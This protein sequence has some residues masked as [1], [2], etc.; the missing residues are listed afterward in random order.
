MQYIDYAVT[1]LSIVG[2]IANSFQKRWCFWVWGFTNTFW[3]VFNI[4]NGSYAQAILYAFNFA[5]AIVGLIKWRKGKSRVHKKLVKQINESLHIELFEWQIQYIF[6]DGEY[7]SEYKYGRKNGKTI[8][9][10]L[11]LILSEGMPLQ[12]DERWG[13]L[14]DVVSKEYAK[15]D[16][17]TLLRMKQFSKETIEIYKTLRAAGVKN[18][19]P[20]LDTN[21]FEL[22][23]KEL[24]K[25]KNEEEITVGW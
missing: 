15:E 4:V 16:S 17:D 6:N 10:I 8:A 12:Y 21:N 7:H 23:A 13:F 3:C 18:L 1:A 25:T 19:R 20:I 2:T 22:Y 14:I 9:N 24:S 5:M 11:K